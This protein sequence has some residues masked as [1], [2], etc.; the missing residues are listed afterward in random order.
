MI[1]AFLQQDFLF[2]AFCNNIVL[3]VSD[4]GYPQGDWI[5]MTTL[6]SKSVEIP[7]PFTSE[8]SGIVS[9]MKGVILCMIEAEQTRR[10]NT[11]QVLTQLH[12]IKGK[13]Q[14]E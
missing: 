4:D 9:Q 14:S 13:Y 1:I 8:D 7:S 12:Y 2:E 5:N 11:K 6:S 3:L 10:W